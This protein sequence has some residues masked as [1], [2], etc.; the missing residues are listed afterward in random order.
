MK[1]Y[2][3]NGTVVFENKVEIADIEITEGLI[4]KIGTG[5]AVESGA[6]VID[7]TGKFVFPGVV[8]FHSHLQETAGLF[9]S[10][11]TYTSGTMAGILNGITTVNCFITQNF[12][13]SLG[14]A[15]TSTMDLAK[16]KVYSDIRWHLTPTRFSD[17][18]YNELGRLIEKG[19]STFK[20]YTTYKQ[21]NLYLA[22]DKILEVIKRLSTFEPTILVHCEDDGVISGA[23][24]GGHNFQSATSINKI[25][26]EDA[27]LT[28]VEKII[29]VCKNTQTDVVVTHVSS[30]DAI[31][32]IELAKRDCPI[33]CECT[34]PNIF[35]NEEM[36]ATEDGHA[37]N[38]F[39][40]LRSSECQKLMEK[41]ILL[42][43]AEIFSSNHRVYSKEAKDRSRNDIR[44]VPEGIPSIGA[45]FHLF[46]DLFM[47]HPQFPFHIF[48]RKLSS[49]PA[50]LAGIYPKKGVIAVDSD[51]D[52]LVINLNGEQREIYGT[53]A[54]SYN[55]W[56][57][58]M[59]KYRFDYV[60]L[61]GEVVVKD[62]QLVDKNKMTGELLV[63]N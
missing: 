61:R 8:D 45:L 1:T 15:I 55:P 62:D 2:I 39:P 20:F 38:I 22:Y 7:A 30:S 51:A 4:S 34:P 42:D 6:K 50:R 35:L 49:N 40:P 19:F 3:L 26:S 11:E 10:N 29:E 44:N 46:T 63:K 54:N 48:Y 37:F 12:N 5:L 16:G 59:T 18:I 13:T 14:Q 27:E 36:Y 41:K 9:T 23:K 58:K 24:Y 28:A 57:G 56:Q 53:L 47:S 25:R 43:Y 33:Y 32:Q 17:V 60:L 52:L 21:L 31:G